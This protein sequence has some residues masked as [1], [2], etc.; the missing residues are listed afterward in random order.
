[1][2]ASQLTGRTRSARY[3]ERWRQ[4]A[5]RS[6]RS[7]RSR[8]WLLWAGAT[9]VIGAVLMFCYLRVAGVTALNSDA[10]GI[11]LQASDVLHGNVLMHGW[12][13]TDVSF[14][15]TELPEY[16]AV[17]AVAGVRPEVVHICA[18]LT[19]TLLVVLA[20]LVARGRSRGAEGVVRA[21]LA[22][23]IMLAPQAG[24][25]TETLVL[26]GSPDHIGTAVPL[27]LLLL[28]LDRPEPRWYVPAGAGLLLAWSIIGDPLVEVIGVI[29]LVLACLLR[30]GRVV[31]A[32]QRE[33]GT[34]RGVGYEASIAA[35]AVLAVPAASFGYRVIRH[36]GGYQVGPALYGKV[37]WQTVRQNVPWAW[38]SVL[39][40][41]SANYPGA[42]GTWNVISALLH[43]AVVAAAVAGVALA[44]WQLARPAR[45]ARLGDRIADVLVLAIAANMAAYLLLVDITGL[46]DAHE[47]APVLPLGAALAG[48]VLGGPLLRFRPRGKPVLVPVLA[49]GLAVYA[50]LL[51]G[52]FSASPQ[53]APQNVQ[54]AA[55]L[56]D[57]HLVHGMSS[58]WMAA[59]TV[60]END[61]QT[62][63]I[64][65]SIH[66]ARH[67]LAPDSWEQNVGLANAATHTANFYVVQQTEPSAAAKQH[68]AL[69][70]FGQPA[71]VYQFQSYTIMVWSRNLLGKLEGPPPVP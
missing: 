15:T 58:Y 23:G 47:I 33:P 50:V 61:A 59:S 68:V 36:F 4:G 31:A 19:Y 49:A 64:S 70:V 41:F 65:V 37:S 28:L 57:H 16:M 42:T 40:L 30:A 17:T 11:V 44:L 7:T 71:H 55:W 38:R 60:V 21:L 8:E 46:W 69:K 39:S 5:H 29:P 32:R 22:A 24:S 67:V 51:G 20:A 25:P 45:A 1:M 56:R 66:G 43:L 54:L 52:A 35:A 12:I 13:D 6:A 53:A 48:R 63:M 9:A 14:F 2:S 3:R 10:A 27:L 34:W 18:A 26:L 62:T